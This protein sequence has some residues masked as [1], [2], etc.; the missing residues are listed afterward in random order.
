MKHLRIILAV[1]LAILALSGC[2]LFQRA[3]VIVKNNSSYTVNAVYISETSNSSWGTDLLTTTIPS[4]GS[5]SFGQLS[6]G[7]Y[8]LRADETYGGYWEKYGIT[9]APNDSYT[10]TLNDP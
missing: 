2:S 6:P 1:S 9:L 3:T 8:D 7:D 10:W 5:H 4:G